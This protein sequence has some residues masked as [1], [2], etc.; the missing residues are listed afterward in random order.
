MLTV[1]RGRPTKY[2]EFDALV[3]GLPETMTKRPKY[4]QGIGVFRGTRGITAWV[5]IRLPHGATI[6]GKTYARGSS[7]EIKMGNLTSWTWNQ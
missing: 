6:K 7:V 5:K 4:L 1:R 3:E 2:A